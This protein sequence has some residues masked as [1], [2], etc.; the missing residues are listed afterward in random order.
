MDRFF[1][2]KHVIFFVLSMLHFT[3]VLAQSPAEF[4][5]VKITNVDSD[6]LFSDQGITKAMNYLASIG[7]NVILPVVWNSHGTTGDYTLYPSRVMT[8]YF[9]QAMYPLFAQ[10]RDPLRRLIIEAHRNGMEVMP[11][12][13]MGFSTSYSQNGG[14]ILAAYPDWALRDSQQR[15]VV[16]NGFDWMSAINPQVQEFMLALV[17]EILDQYDVDGLE[18]SDRIPALPVEGGYDSVTTHIYRAE[19]NGANPPQNYRD[20]AWMRWRA[21]QLN[22]FYRQVRDSIKA[23]S[24]HLI[25]S[26]SPSVYP[27]S[28]EEYLQDSKTW[29]DQGIVDHLIPQLYRYNYNDYLYELNKS[30]SYVAPDKRGYFY[31]GMLLYLKGD[32]YLISP[33]F[34][35]KSIQA[36]RERQVNGE[37]FFFYEGLRQNNN[38]LGDTLRATYYSQPALLPHRAG[39]VWRP[40]GIIVNEDDP[41][42]VVVGNWEPS[43]IAG[44][45]PNIL[46][47]KTPDYGS[48]SYCFD[49]PVSAW[50]DVLAYVVTG[51]LATNRAGYTVYSD[52]DST[53]VTLNQQNYYQA[54]WQPLTTVYLNAGQRRVLKLD[55]RGVSASQYV[56]ADAAMLLLNRK[57]SPEVI[58]TDIATR[59]TQAIAMP[60][61]FDLAQNYPNPFNSQTTFRY[62]LSQPGAVKLT[63]LNLKKPDLRTRFKPRPS[64]RMA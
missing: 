31:A 53:S 45:K 6:V 62:Y 4:R 23:R 17:T 14:H 10:E 58:I 28:Y 19:H 12:F 51:P 50:Y 46:I 7:A 61:F 30:L 40:Q 20:P 60:T 44:Y 18:F 13:E 32:H 54:G 33:D 25:V 49:I 57:L 16:K 39:Q 9:G 29:F 15:L 22:T 11:W 59:K 37:A 26:S 21:N 36:N 41:A 47:K 8:R 5:A 42:A 55:N 43:S 2:F 64:C 24:E 27:W 38:R 48:I 35:L 1:L 52:V 63:L 3:N 56:V 34:F